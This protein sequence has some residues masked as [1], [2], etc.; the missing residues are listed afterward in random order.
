MTIR[1]EIPREMIKPATLDRWPRGIA[2]HKGFRILGTPL[3]F[4]DVIGCL[5]FLDHL[6]AKGPRKGERIITSQ[7]LSLAFG[8]KRRRNDILGLG[9][10]Q[11]IRLGQMALRIYPAGLG[12]GS[13]QLEVSIKDRKILYCGGVRMA[14]PLIC[15]AAEVPRCDLLLLDAPISEPKPP[16]PAT[17]SKALQAWLR[18]C[19]DEKQRPFMIFGNRAAALEAVYSASGLGRPLR[20]QRRLF[21]MIRRMSVDLPL[22]NAVLRLGKKVKD[23]EGALISIA[24]WHKSRFFEEPDKR[25]AYIGPGR[26]VP[27]FADVAFRMGESEDRP[28]MLAYIKQTGATQ[29]ALGDMTDESLTEP[30]QEMGIEA[31]RLTH[32]E[33]IPLPFRI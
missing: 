17:M 18:A 6:E 5:R 26:A 1:D 20:V 28:G 29:V 10:T 23:D 14:R 16:A 22:G 15:A 2:Y 11:T 32:P 9:H 7:L 24:D 8:E 25:V 27:P 33:Q 19:I 13:A 21:E 30:L 4:G 3:G 31:F 12:P